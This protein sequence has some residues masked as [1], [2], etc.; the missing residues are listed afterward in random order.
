MMDVLSNPVFWVTLLLVEA[1][2]ITGVT[3]AFRSGRKHERPQRDAH[4]R[5]ITTKRGSRHDSHA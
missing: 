5:F 1:V 3:M 4:G 2:Y